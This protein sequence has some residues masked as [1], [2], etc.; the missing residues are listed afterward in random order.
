VKG[1][2]AILRFLL[3]CAERGEDAALVTLTDVTASAVR[4]PGEHMAVAEDGR[5]IGSFSGGCVEAAVIAEAQDAL[6]EGRA[7]AVRYGEGSPYIDIRL[8]CGGGV[9]LL[10]TP[11]PDV[12]VIA[13][14]LAVLDARLPLGL[15]LSSDGGIAVCPAIATGWVGSNFTVRH[16]PDPRIAILGH[17]AEP[18]ALLAVARAYGAETL[19]LSPQETLV[20]AARAHGAAAWLR[21]LGPSP[22][23]V[24]D[25][26]TAVVALFHDHDWETA[27]LL[28]ALAQAPFFIGAMGSRRTQSERRRRLAEAGGSADD[29][30][31]IVGP[32]GLIHATRDPE[33]LAISIMA[34][35]AEAYEAFVARP[36]ADDRTVDQPFAC[37][38]IA[39]SRV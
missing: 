16:D 23:L 17:G 21:T 35:V 19:L 10:F 14:A 15:R 24:V 38:E 5:A 29:I 1:A 11:R 2:R 18:A 31:R 27:L 36:V 13:A 12:D 33:T 6:A 39:A 25:P 9:D 8:P 32:I 4:R 7:R 20:E 30:A 22:D 26:W 3:D 34:Q 37:D 28:Q